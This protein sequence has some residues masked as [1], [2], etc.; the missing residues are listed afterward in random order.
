MS[1]AIGRGAARK[2]LNFRS[3]MAA[4]MKH[5][6]FW[7]EHDLSGIPDHMFDKIGALRDASLIVGTPTIF[8]KLCVILSSC[9]ETAK[10]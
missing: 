9:C 7:F 1:T 8:L 2:I 6:A 3:A 4:L 5:E 10:S